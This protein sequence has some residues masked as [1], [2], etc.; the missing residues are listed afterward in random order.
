MFFIIGLT[1]FSGAGKTTLIQRIRKY[2]DINYISLGEVAREVLKNKNLSLEKQTLIFKNKSAGEFWL[3]ELRQMK[4]DH[5]IL[6][7][8]GIRSRADYEFF[9]SQSDSFV[10]VM[11]IAEKDVRYKRIYNRNLK[12]DRSF[13]TEPQKH[14]LW[15]WEFGIR[16]IFMEIDRFILNN[17]EINKAEQE[18]YKIMC[19]YCDDKIKRNF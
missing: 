1:G 12:K 3:E 10:L 4:G 14:D 18:L 16:D 8:D 11:V 17:E 19:E 13:V 2:L 9:K 7:I 5:K 15:E 6:V